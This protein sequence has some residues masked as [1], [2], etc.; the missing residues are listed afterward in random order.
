MTEILEDLVHPVEVTLER[1][2]KRT[3][4]HNIE[5][6]ENYLSVFHIA[7]NET[8]IV[9]NI[10]NITPEEVLSVAPGEGHKPVSVLTDI[11]CEELT[12]PHLFLTGK[13]GHRVERD[14]VLSVVK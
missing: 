1:E 6:T 14:V 7:L 5:I 3:D 4:D 9:P 13:F 11:F 2:G 10:P 12:H 8:S